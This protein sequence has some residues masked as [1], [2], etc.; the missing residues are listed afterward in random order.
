MRRGRA[1]RWL[2]AIGPKRWRVSSPLRLPPPAVPDD[3][4]AFEDRGLPEIA[5]LVSGGGGVLRP[6]AERVT[7][8]FPAREGETD[9][10]VGY[11]RRAPGTGPSPLVVNW[12]GTDTWKEELNDRVGPFLD[13]RGL[14][15]LLL[16]MPG[17]GEAPIVGSLDAER[18]FAATL[19][20]AGSQPDVDPRRVCVYGASFGGYWAVK[21]AHLYRERLACAV[22]HGGGVHFDFELEWN[23]KMDTDDPFDPLE[24]RAAAFGLSTL[25][26][27]LELSPK[28][29]LLSQ[30]CS[31]HPL[32]RCFS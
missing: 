19:D 15:V 30:A 14:S 27:W 11:L 12:S 2:P 3:D 31:T 6:S 28:L 23:L 18:M 26:E 1:G 17:T 10:V 16:D 9:I 7:I 13:E 5:G 20:W 24:T 4:L 25:D 22:N 21:V 29:S 32:R 8:P